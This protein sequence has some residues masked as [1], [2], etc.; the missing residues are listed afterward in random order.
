[1]DADAVVC[2]TIVVGALVAAVFWKVFDEFNPGVTISDITDR[3]VP[4]R[5]YLCSAP[6]HFWNVND[7]H[8]YVK[9]KSW[10]IG[11][12]CEPIVVFQY[13]RR[14]ETAPEDARYYI[15]TPEFNLQSVVLRVPLRRLKRATLAWTTGTCHE[16]ELVSHIRRMH[17]GPLSGHPFQP[18]PLHPCPFAQAAFSTTTPEKVRSV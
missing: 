15:A 7:L 5:F 3:V 8:A 1:M 18:E 13:Y 2:V 6:A 11:A 9:E 10:E 16:E 14:G 4:E 17:A 12:R